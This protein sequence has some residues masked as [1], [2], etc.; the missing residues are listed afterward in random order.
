MEGC[1]SEFLR[2]SIARSTNRL[3]RWFRYFFVFSQ[4]ARGKGRE[5]MS[6]INK[7]AKSFELPLSVIGLRLISI[8]QRVAPMEKSTDRIAQG[9]NSGILSANSAPIRPSI[10]KKTENYKQ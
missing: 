2:Y 4:T 5:K 1:E 10:S 7:G 6:K 9:K 3:N 8:M